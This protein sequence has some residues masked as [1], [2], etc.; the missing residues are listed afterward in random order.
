MSNQ[1]DKLARMYAL[2]LLSALNDQPHM[3]KEKLFADAVA[4]YRWLLADKKASEALEIYWHEFKAHHKTLVIGMEPDVRI[5]CFITWFVEQSFHTLPPLI[6][7][8]TTEE[9]QLPHTRLT[10]FSQPSFRL[11]T[12]DPVESYLMQWLYWHLD[13]LPADGAAADRGLLYRWGDELVNQLSE[14]HSFAYDDYPALFKNAVRF[15][16]WCLNDLRSWDTFMDLFVLF[17]ASEAGQTIDQADASLADVCF[18]NWFC[19]RVLD[20]A[21][22]EQSEA[23]GGR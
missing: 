13:H 16:A 2:E 23:N 21:E 12:G 4:Y 19:Q 14:H 10:R 18:V 3:D 15:F 1:T 22:Q 6:V 5:G 8:P 11:P 20:S 9:H 7:R 17:L